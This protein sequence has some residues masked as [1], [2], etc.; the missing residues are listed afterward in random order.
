MPDRT[1]CK[2]ADIERRLISGAELDAA[3][4]RKDGG[5]HDTAR[6][7]NAKKTQAAGVTAIGRETEETLGQQKSAVLGAVAGN[8]LQVEIAAAGAV[9][10]AQERPSGT[11]GVEALIAGMAAPW[12]QSDGT[13][14][15]IKNAI[16]AG[17]EAVRTAAL[18]TDHCFNLPLASFGMRE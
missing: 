6:R 16:A 8:V 12:A 10:V 1:D 15:Q 14:T 3:V 11:R 5:R 9:G 2:A 13:E 18:R 17:T 7:K 4:L